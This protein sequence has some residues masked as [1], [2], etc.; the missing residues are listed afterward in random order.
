MNLPNLQKK[1]RQKYIL[2]R[3]GCYRK[4]VS[5][6]LILQTEQGFFIKEAFQFDLLFFPNKTNCYKYTVNNQVVHFLFNL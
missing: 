2:F 4:I 6:T 1:Q 5:L 3:A